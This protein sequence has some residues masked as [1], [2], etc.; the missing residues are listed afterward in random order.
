[1]IFVP[2]NQYKMNIYSSIARYEILQMM[3]CR[4][5]IFKGKKVL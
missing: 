1:M 5:D 2:L 3:Y 4:T